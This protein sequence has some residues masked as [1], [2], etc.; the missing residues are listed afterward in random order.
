MKRDLV[1][2]PFLLLIGVALF[3]LRFTGMPVHIAISV[4][5]A[6]VLAVYTVLT[7]REWKIPAF[8]IIMRACYGIALISGVVIMNVH[9]VAVLTLLHRVSAVSFMALIVALL[10][11]KAALRKK[12]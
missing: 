11:V 9:G 7:R 3:L 4:V 6:I 5:G 10:S 2:A 8:E 12:D 1:F